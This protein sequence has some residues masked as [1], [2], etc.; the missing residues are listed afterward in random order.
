MPRCLMIIRYSALS[1]EWFD[2]ST[3]R[4]ASFLGEAAEWPSEQPAAAPHASSAV[5]SASPGSVAPG[6]SLPESQADEE[7]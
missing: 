3:P 7:T 6:S 1:G 5:F 4:D 2:M